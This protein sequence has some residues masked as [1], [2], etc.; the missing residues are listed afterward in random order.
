MTAL[1][2]MQLR[3]QAAALNLVLPLAATLLLTAS[4]KI[5][6]P[7]YPVPMTLQTF[8][9]IGLGFVL[10]SRRAAVAILLYLAEGAAGLPV[11]SGTPQKGIGLAYM[12][13]PTGGYLLGYLA[14]VLLAGW[15]VSRGWAVNGLAASLSALLAGAIVYLPG[16]LWLGAVIGFDKPVLQYGLYPFILGDVTKAILAALLFITG[17]G[18]I[19]GRAGR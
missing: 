19:K 3:L 18:G 17:R 5:S 8:V 15:T 13:G 12:Q 9:V 1:T 2:A 6:V 7:F 10:G 4:A 11:F 14:A 16:L